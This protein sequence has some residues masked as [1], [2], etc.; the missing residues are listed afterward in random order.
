MPWLGTDNNN[1]QDAA[2]IHLHVF[3]SYKCFSTKKKISDSIQHF[4][5]ACHSIFRYGNY[6]LFYTVVK[7]ERIEVGKF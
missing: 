1:R 4:F 5:E 2:H 6:E 7:K 3:E